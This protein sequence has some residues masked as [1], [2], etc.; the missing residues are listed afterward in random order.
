MDLPTRDIGQ[1]IA[2]RANIVVKAAIM[3]ANDQGELLL[4]QHAEQGHWRIPVGEMRPGETI[5]G[6][7]LR[8]LWEETGWTTE[9]MSFE[10]LYSGPELRQVHANGDEEYYVI[11]LFKARIIL[12]HLVE[13]R[14]NSD[15]GLKFFEPN[16]LPPM[17]SIS[18]TLLEQSGLK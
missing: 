6:A 14:V 7:A 4:I 12:D 10:S 5:E 15:A 16:A 3:A 8:E 13:A 1:Y 11:A 18:Q 2:K 17:N 9:S